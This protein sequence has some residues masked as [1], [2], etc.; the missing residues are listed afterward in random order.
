MTSTLAL[1]K[2]TIDGGTQSRVGL[3]QDV[4]DDYSVVIRDGT[5]FPPVTVF[6][7]G[8][9]YWLAD[10]FHRL[11]AYRKAGAM[12]LPAA[13][14]QGTRRDAILFSVGA[15]AAH[16]L[17]RTNDDKRRAVTTLLN[18]KEWSAWSDREIAKRC[19]VSDRF[20]NSLRC[21]TANGSQSERTY[22]HP[23]TGKPTTMDTAKIG[24]APPRADDQ[25]EHDRQR[26]ETVDALPPSIRA[27][28]AAKA[29]RRNAPTGGIEDDLASV[30]AER[31]ELREANAALS[32]DVDRLAREVAKFEG[33]RV[34][35]EQGGFEKVIAA[36]DE[37]IRV[38]GT[39]VATESRDKA[40]WK[41]SADYWRG[42]AVK[43]GW[44]DPDVIPLEGGVN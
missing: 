12:E 23:K 38:L 32:A 11:A 27:M 6:F 4:V 43:L 7:D 17:R 8:K 22:T 3:N 31:D 26:Q 19:D 42:E 30:I 18:D 20:V 39:Q 28:E 41:Q 40:R 29:E 24:K 33:M 10:G 1:D 21:D 44:S 2:I 9:K 16:G 5:D 25:A 15:N 34:Q 37:E 13:V 36:K 35:F 14:H